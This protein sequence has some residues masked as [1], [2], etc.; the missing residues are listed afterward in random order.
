[1]VL[2]VAAGGA[3]GAVLR[4]G[5]SGLVQGRT[6]AVFPYGTLA[7]NVVGCL[8]MGVISELAESRGALQPGT[9]AVITVGVLGGFTTF[10]AFGNETL[11]LLRD[12]ERAL[13][14]GNVAANLILALAAVWAGRVAAAGWWR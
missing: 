13:A 10:S 9:R 5:L 4:Y 3:V 2:L 12:G 6:R 7:V 8:L 1:M 14:A 11:N